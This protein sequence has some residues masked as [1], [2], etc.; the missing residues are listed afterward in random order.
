MKA[1][2][3]IPPPLP[4]AA[5]GRVEAARLLLVLAGGAVGARVALHFG[6]PLPGC[7]LRET[8]GVPCPF[9]G[10][11][12]AFGAMASLDFVQAF[13]W[14]PLVSA[15]AC[16]MFVLLLVALAR[17]RSTAGLPERVG[18]AF[19][20]AGRRWLLAAALGLNW[21]YLWFHLPR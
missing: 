20:S 3:A 4:A 10:S 16:V 21:F 13:R 18:G 17:R 12:R 19:A 8:T 15:G 1:V 14:N 5:S 6:I 2:E 9:C 11:T 7:L